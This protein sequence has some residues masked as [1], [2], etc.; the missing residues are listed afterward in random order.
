MKNK[1]LTYVQRYSIEMMLKTKI[2]KEEVILF[3][4]IKTIAL[5][6]KNGASYNK[7][8]FGSLQNPINVMEAEH[9]GAGDIIKGIK[10]LTN[11]FTPPEGA[12]NTFIALYAKLEAYQNDLFQH[13]HIENNIL[14]PKAVEIEKKFLN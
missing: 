4:T 2:K 5:A 11:D 13:I 8:P 14:F 10:Q 6:S 1:Y 7:P 12:C 9:D 3:P